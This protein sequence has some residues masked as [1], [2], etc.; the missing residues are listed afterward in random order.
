MN[1]KHN[2]STQDFHRNILDKPDLER[3]ISADDINNLK[4]P[5]VSKKSFSKFRELVKKYSEKR[6]FPEKTEF[7]NLDN[8]KG[9]LLMTLS[10]FIYAL[11]LM[12]QKF[13]FNKYPELS[14][15]QQ[16]IFRGL[17]MIVVNCFLIFKEN[18]K[19]MFD[20]ETNSNL[21]K[22]VIYGFI[23]EFLLFLSTNYLRI[24]TSSTFYLLYAVICS[25]VSGLILGEVVTKSDIIIIISVFLSACLIVKP[26]FGD[27]QDT[28][29]GICMG[30]CST[31]CFCMMVIYH[32]FLHG[33][34]SAFTI[35]FY[36]G[37]CYFM[38][39]VVD[40]T[41]NK[42]KFVS[43]SGP[44]MHLFL[45]SCIYTFS[46]YIYIVAINCGKVSYVLPFENTN[47]VFALILGHFI[48]K[49]SCDTLDVIGTVAILALC[50]YRSVVLINEEEETNEQSCINA[51]EVLINK[52]SDDS[53]MQSK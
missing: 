39:G 50:V 12:Y 19:F 47:I 5:P 8:L 13:L 46:C 42:E 17:L 44:L 38:E 36:F 15:S 27:G 48:L 20:K 1:I 35:N 34:V 33:R 31:I 10:A 23:G 22:R 53:E 51:E 21:A 41:I 14:F 24:N 7:S 18:D 40:F 16:N 11:L 3:K 6:L 37:V 28:F 4:Y 26:F 25:L 2:L 9:S 32:R 29:L 49:E 45:L 52:K 43:D 30:S